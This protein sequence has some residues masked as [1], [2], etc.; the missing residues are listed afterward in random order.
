MSDT[1]LKQVKPYLVY[2]NQMRAG[3]PIM[4]YHCKWYA[5]KKGLDLVKDLGAQGQDVDAA[6]SHLLGELSDLE[7]MKA[8]MGQVDQEDMHTFVT[9]FVLS[10]FATAD[11]SERNDPEI[12][13]KHALDFKRLQDFINV[14]TLF[15][16]LDENWETK[17]KYFVFKCGTIMKALKAGVQ[18]DF[19]GN[20]NDPDP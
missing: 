11:K 12:T 1:I 16:P 3:V 8:A 20:P 19:R 7:S 18:P 6:K 9:N 10:V 4:A 13:K 5:V 14:L 2:A 15:E 17:R